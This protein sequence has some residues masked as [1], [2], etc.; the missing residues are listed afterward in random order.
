MANKEH[1]ARLKQGV[2]NVLATMRYALASGAASAYAGVSTWIAE[3]QVREGIRQ[4]RQRVMARLRSTRWQDLVHQ[5]QWF[6]MGLG[7]LLLL[8]VFWKLPQWYANSWKERIV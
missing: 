8:L 2:V 1:L 3:W 7:V 4:T 5:Y 6:L